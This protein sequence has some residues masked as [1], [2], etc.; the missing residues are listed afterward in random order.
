MSSEIAREYFELLA[1]AGMTKH[2]GSMEA[3]HKLVEMCHIDDGKHVLDVGCGVGATP[4]YLA[5]NIGCRVMGVDLLDKM[6]DQSREWAKA[7]GLEELLDFRVADARELPFDDNSFDAIISESVNVFFEDKSEAMREYIRVA[8]P[9]GYV[10]MTEITWLKPP[11]P[12]VEDSFKGMVDTHP[13]DEGGWKVVLEDAGLI[14]VIGSVHRIDIALEGKGRFERYRRRITI[15]K[16]LSML[17]M[18]LRD[19]RMRQIVEDGASAVSKDLRN[20]VGY[21]VYT[22]RKP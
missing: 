22:G 14:D 15:K 9:G 18:F 20:V 1:D 13:L 5:K 11:S 10:G 21:G 16:L 6:V 7:E 4:V 3:T 19:R 17:G 8:N 2:L 12:E